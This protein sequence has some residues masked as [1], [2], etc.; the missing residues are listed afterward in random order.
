MDDPPRKTSSRSVSEPERVPAGVLLTL[1]AALYD[2]LLLIAILFVASAVAVIANGGEANAADDAWFE[3]YLF[4]AGYPYFG[5]CWTRSGQTL[6][7]KTWRIELMCA[8]GKP[9][10]VH[11]AVVRYVMAA[12]SW[13]VGGLGFVWMLADARQRSWHDITSRTRLVRIEA[14]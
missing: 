14:D 10:R 9:V 12:L 1:A 6:G 4:A 2:G 3:L 5:W 11:N 7:M 13:F 8:D